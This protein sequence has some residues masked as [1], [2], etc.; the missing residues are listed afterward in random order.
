MASIIASTVVILPKKSEGTF[1]LGC[2]YGSTNFPVTVPETSSYTLTSYCTTTVNPGMDVSHRTL[3]KKLKNIRISYTANS[4]N[5]T[6]GVGLRQD[7]QTASFTSVIS[8]TETSAGEYVTHADMCAD[9]TAFDE[10]YE[11]QLQLTSTGNVSIK[12][13]EYEYELI[14]D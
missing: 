1:N 9:G 12:Q 4:A 6:V 13:V 11:I 7:S 10:A 14:N 3:R 2:L 5:G 8:K